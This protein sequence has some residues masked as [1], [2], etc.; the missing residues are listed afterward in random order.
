MSRIRSKN[1]Q[2]ELHFRRLLWKEGLRYRIHLKEMP[3]KPDIAFPTKKVAVFVDSHFWHGYN[4]EN[5]EGKLKNDY[6]RNKIRYNMERDE[7]V[8]NQLHGLGWTVIRF[9]E[10][11]IKSEPEKCVQ[12][13]KSAVRH[14]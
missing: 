5:L 7:K 4:W 9:W 1:T 10:H 11:E 3:G 8:N 13:V 12:K 6:W 2:V 14:K